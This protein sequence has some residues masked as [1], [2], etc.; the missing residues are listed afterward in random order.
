LPGFHNLVAQTF[1]SVNYHG[2]KLFLSIKFYRNYKALNL[3]K[4][5][6]IW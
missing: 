4:V 5:F 6:I 3:R 2:E 1:L